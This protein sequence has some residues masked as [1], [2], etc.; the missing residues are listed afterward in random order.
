MGVWSDYRQIG[1]FPIDSFTAVGSAT[2]DPNNLLLYKASLI[3][4]SCTKRLGSRP[5]DDDWHVSC[6]DAKSN[7]VYVPASAKD[8]NGRSEMPSIVGEVIPTAG[9]FKKNVIR[10]KIPLGIVV[11]SMNDNWFVWGG[12]LPGSNTV[13]VPKTDGN[14]AAS[15]R[16]G[17]LD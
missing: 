10:L 17:R 12:G 5:S 13:M 9:D 15:F 3:K 7:K 1:S 6:W 16:V 2:D 8:L 14:N 4:G 11:V